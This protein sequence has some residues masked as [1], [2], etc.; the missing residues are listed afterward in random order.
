MRV[1]HVRGAIGLLD[2][3]LLSEG[4]RRFCRIIFHLLQPHVAAYTLSIARIRIG[5]RRLIIYELA[6]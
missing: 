4:A 2:E 3:M 5:H 1:T 6:L